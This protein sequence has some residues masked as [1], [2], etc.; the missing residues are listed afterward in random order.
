[1]QLGSRP[2]APDLETGAFFVVSAPERITRAGPG[3]LGGPVPPVH[4]ANV[5]QD[6]LERGVGELRVLFAFD[7][8]HL[9][10][11]GQSSDGIR[12]RPIDFCPQL[13][14]A[15]IDTVSLSPERPNLA[16]HAP[17][18][19]VPFIVSLD[20]L[21]GARTGGLGW[22]LEAE[23]SAAARAPELHP[24]GRIHF[25]VEPPRRRFLGV[26]SAGAASAIAP[27]AVAATLAPAA[28]VPLISPVPTV[29]TPSRDTALL[30]LFDEYMSTVAE[31]QRVYGLYKRGQ[32]K[33]QAKH[34]MPE[35]LLVRP[36][37]AEL[38]LPDKPGD[39]SSYEWCIQELRRAREKPSCPRGGHPGGIEVVSPAYA[40]S[41]AI[42]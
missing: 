25:V 31:H 14:L 15:F 13:I 4:G 33:H 10:L 21:V 28:E 22:G 12:P 11:H 35:V 39:G 3:P 32:A 23:D 8:R 40:A 27:A 37:D 9:R 34:P 5:T 41:R 30:Q 16:G 2:K 20:D 18:F 7:G 26:L 1:M 24:V 19:G 6:R 17:I 42:G 36:E 38:G 29:A